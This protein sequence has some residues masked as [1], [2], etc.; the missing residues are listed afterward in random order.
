MPRSNIQHPIYSIKSMGNHVFLARAK[1][2]ASYSGASLLPP[3]KRG[4]LGTNNKGIGCSCSVASARAT[5]LLGERRT[6]T[7]AR[8]FSSSLLVLLYTYK[9]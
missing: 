9:T 7:K 3:L 1:D 6:S 8:W 5:L 2:H 4:C